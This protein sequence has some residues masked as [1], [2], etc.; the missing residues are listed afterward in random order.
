V[1][2][3][4]SPLADAEVDEA[5][6]YIARGDPAAALEWLEHLLEAFGCRMRYQDRGPGSV[7]AW[8]TR[9]AQHKTERER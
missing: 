8:L 9:I 4:W 7:G 2:V 5:I 3:T 6:A 1:K